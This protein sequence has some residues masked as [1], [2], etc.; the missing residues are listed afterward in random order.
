MEEKPD[1]YQTI[2]EPNESRTLDE[3][4]GGK[5][6]DFFFVYKD[7]GN[8]YQALFELKD[9]LIGYKAALQNSI[10]VREVYVENAEDTGFSQ[11]KLI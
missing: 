5:F 10:D 4:F 2:T 7:N 11:E 8:V 1:G 3:F 9:V 6:D